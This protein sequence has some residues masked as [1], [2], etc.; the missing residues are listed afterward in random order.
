MLTERFIPVSLEIPTGKY[1]DSR[2]EIATH[3]ATAVSIDATQADLN[4]FGQI[5][6]NTIIL[7]DSPAKVTQGTK[8][9]FSEDEKYEIGKIRT[10]EN[11]AGETIAYRCTVV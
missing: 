10:C 2:P 6:N 11:V 9:I 1:V 8:V 5:K 3:N 4:Y 7:I